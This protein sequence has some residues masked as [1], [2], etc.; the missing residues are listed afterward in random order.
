[1]PNRDIH[2]QARIQR[3]L[4]HKPALSIRA[5][6]P[7][8]PTPAAHGVRRQRRKLRPRKQ[9]R[10]GV[11]QEA[12][13]RPRRIRARRLPFIL[14]SLR[15]WTDTHPITVRQIV[16]PR[17]PQ[18]PCGVTIPQR[19][20]RRRKFPHPM[21]CLTPLLTRPRLGRQD[22]RVRGQAPLGLLRLPRRWLRRTWRDCQVRESHLL[23]R[24]PWAPCRP[25]LHHRL[26][27]WRRRNL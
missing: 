4:R 21:A 1:M 26:A 17:P 20:Q 3:R 22:T 25:V 9:R 11:G 19:A 18:H 16:H 10:F 12:I 7:G 6:V 13:T 15:R 8:T 23:L 27:L 14:P 24:R 2:R 5:A